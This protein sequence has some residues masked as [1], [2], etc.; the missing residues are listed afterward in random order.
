[1][2]LDISVILWTVINI[3]LVVAVAICI[4]KGIISVMNLINGNR[5]MN[6]KVD[7][8]LKKLE[9]KHK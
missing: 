9:D 5:E 4:Y 8:I 2:E 3:T 7:I 1:M 6:N